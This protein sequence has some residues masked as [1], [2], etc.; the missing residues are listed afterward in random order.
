[1]QAMSRFSAIATKGALHPQTHAPEAIPRNRS[2]LLL[3]CRTAIPHNSGL[4][5][6]LARNH[7]NEDQHHDRK[8]GVSTQI[9]ILS[10]WCPRQSMDRPR[11]TVH[12]PGLPKV[13]E[14]MGLQTRYLITKVSQGNGKAEATVKSMKKIIRSAWRG[15]SLDE[16]KLA[17]ALLQYRNTPSRKDGLAPAQKLYGRPIQDTLPAH[18]R[19]FSPEWQRSTSMAEE[20]AQSTVDNVVKSY[21]SKARP[22]P[23]ITIGSRVALQNHE[24]K[25]WDIYRTVTDI[26]PH[27]RYFIRTQSGRV[28]VRNRRFLRCRIPPSIPTLTTDILPTHNLE[29]PRRS[30]RVRNKPNRLIE[31]IGI[32]SFHVKDDQEAPVGGRCRKPTEHNMNSELF[33]LYCSCLCT[34]QV[35]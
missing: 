21:N 26:T 4:L 16:N 2:R 5:I 17:R 35:M 18:R 25:R 7:T 30:T 15:R 23:E 32:S 9:V 6:R 24:T 19:A 31:E 29:G 11:P 3:T 27:R 28:L 10:H 22:L 34:A 14:T 8:A 1:M 33:E 13:C 12:I 20:Q